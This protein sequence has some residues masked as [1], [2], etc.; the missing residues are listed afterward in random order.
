ML[1]LTLDCNPA[2]I[3]KIFWEIR[4]RVVVSFILE[5]SGKEKNLE[6]IREIE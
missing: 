4:T 5:L 2:K 6:V 1:N 3:I